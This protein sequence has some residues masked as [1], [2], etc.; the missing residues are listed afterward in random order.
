MR[1]TGINLESS[2]NVLT[3]GARLAHEP[4]PST[5]THRLL[6]DALALPA[7]PGL[8]RFCSMAGR[9]GGHTFLEFRT[10]AN[11]GRPTFFGPHART[12][13]DPD[14]IAAEIA[15]VRRPR[16]RPGRG[17]RPRAAGQGEPRDL[18]DGSELDAMSPMKETARKLIDRFAGPRLVDLERQVAELQVAA[19]ESRRL[20]ERLSDV[21]DVVVELLVPAVDRDDERLKEA[22]GRLGKTV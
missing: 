5:S 4:G 9:T 7:R 16:D 20:N 3:N 17:H 11:R 19:E 15:V 18:P 6:V 22:L 21:L 2:Y 12:Y 13:A 10:A 1:F 14:E 8:W